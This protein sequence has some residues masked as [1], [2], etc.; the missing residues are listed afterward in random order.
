MSACSHKGKSCLAFVQPLVSRRQFT[1]RFSTDAAKF[2]FWRFHSSRRSP[3]FWNLLL[4]EIAPTEKGESKGD[5]SSWRSFLE[6]FLSVKSLVS[7]V[8]SW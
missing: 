3:F 1:F 8:K 7:K 4:I 5:S 6:N 2:W